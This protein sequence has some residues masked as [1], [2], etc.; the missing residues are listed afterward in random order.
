MDN[1]KDIWD[2]YV[3]YRTITERELKDALAKGDETRTR[4]LK[5]S[6]ELNRHAYFCLTF[7]QFDGFIDSRFINLIDRKTLTSA[8]CDKKRMAVRQG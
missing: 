1:L 8:G 5:L 3:L 2:S 4:S 6:L 7:A